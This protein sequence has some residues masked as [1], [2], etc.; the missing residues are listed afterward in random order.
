ML[1]T[2]LAV[3]AVS[4]NP[5][6]VITLPPNLPLVASGPINWALREPAL[7]VKPGTRALVTRIAPGSLPGVVEVKLFDGTN[8]LCW[9]EDVGL[10]TPPP[11]MGDPSEPNSAESSQSARPVSTG[12]RRPRRR[13][14]RPDFSQVDAALARLADDTWRTQ[15]FVS[16]GP[17]VLMTPI[18]SMPIASM[19]VFSMDVFSMPVFQMPVFQMAVF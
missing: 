13:K 11:S 12:L 3:L 2:C 9:L 17:S 8:R 7:V 14:F 10:P 19:P 18:L 16:T 5:G 4:L 1:A 15:A 6:T